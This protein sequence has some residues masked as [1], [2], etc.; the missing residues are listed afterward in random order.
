MQ[1]SG[2]NDA[3]VD[4]RYMDCAFRQI[5]FRSVRNSEMDPGET[6]IDGFLG[7]RL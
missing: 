2:T 7:Q 1:V 3:G 4:N 5:G 6:I